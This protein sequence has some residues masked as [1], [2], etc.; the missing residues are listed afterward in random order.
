MGRRPAEGR[1]RGGAGRLVASAVVLGG[2]TVAVGGVPRLE[3]LDPAQGFKM[4]RPSATA[5]ACA[6]R[7]MFSSAPPDDLLA[8]A[9]RELLARDDEATAVVNGRVESTTWTVGVYGRR[10]VT[11]TG[12]VVRFATTVML[13]MEHGH[14][15]AQQ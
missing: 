8:T 11:L 2:C 9:F 14:H 12:D 7:G 6:G 15:H 10:C 13:P 4:L 5:T 3:Q 1:S